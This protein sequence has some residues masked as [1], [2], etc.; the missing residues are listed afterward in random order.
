[1]KQLIFVLLATVIGLAAHSQKD[2]EGKVV[3][4]ME[5]DKDE[6]KPE[7][8]VWFAPSKLKISFKEKETSDAEYVVVRLDSGK[9]FTIN[10]AQ[11]HFK[12]KKLQTRL[13]NNFVS[14]KKDI[15]GHSTTS[16]LLETNS[17]GTGLGGI[18]SMNDIVYDLAD[19]LSY[20]IPEQYKGNTE[21]MMVYQNRIA[22]GASLQIS[23]FFGGMGDE[24]NEKAATKITAKAI[25][26][27]PMILDAAEF[28]IPAGY[29]LKPKYE[30]PVAD[31][32]GLSSR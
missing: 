8:T 5:A 10:K 1:M 7:L 30:E 22:L 24:E 2:F 21:L 13:G 31:S 32:R 4:L 19:N 26:V 3:Y 15:A 6:K 28:E 25:A 17:S 20:T 29:T 12:V 14:E 27:T 11:E 9:I 18:L 23:T 16:V